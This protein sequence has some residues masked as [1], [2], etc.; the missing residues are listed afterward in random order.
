MKK[1]YPVMQYSESAWSALCESDDHEVQNDVVTVVWKKKA[2]C[3]DIMASGQK[4][5]YI[6]RRL[7]AS[8][9]AVGLSGSGKVVSAA[10]VDFNGGEMGNGLSDFASERI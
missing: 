4:V 7:E 2:V 3:L 1:L 10:A 9:Q 5:V 8:L 6:L